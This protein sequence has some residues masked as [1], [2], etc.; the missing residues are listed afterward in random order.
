[1]RSFIPLV[2]P[3]VCAITGAM[4]QASAPPPPVAGTASEAN[5]DAPVAP[6]VSHTT[7]LKQD[8]A[9]RPVISTRLNGQG[10]FDMVVDTGAQSTVIAPS[11]ARD[12][13]LPP[14]PGES[15]NVVG[16]SGS[17]QVAL[18]PVDE[19]DTELFS[20]RYVA[21][22]GL[23]NPGSTNARGILGMEHFA[24]GKLS[25]DHREGRLSYGPSSPP[26]V[27]VF[28]VKGRLEVNG[29][30]HVPVSIDGV[31]FD[32]LVDTGAS[33]TVIN[34]AAMKA[35][36]WARD[37][38]R[39]K[40]AGGI[41]GATHAATGVMSTRLDKVQ[42]G[43]A[44]LSNVNVMVTVPTDGADDDAPSIILGIDVL[45]ALARYAVDFPRSELQIVVPQ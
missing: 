33:A 38:A 2:L 31:V 36:G 8:R 20:A 26:G 28:A 32:A 9:G 25:F 27:G 6:T 5:P 23:P 13:R 4:V 24:L 39:L 12:L 16:V 22:P 15:I 43:P 18:Y 42:I 35:L 21:L 11:L 10:P 37:D 40:A 44:K 30:L 29:L 34:W 1:M 17:S 19:L 45:S 14:L 7:A 3:L 41:R